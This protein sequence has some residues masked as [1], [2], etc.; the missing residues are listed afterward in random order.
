MAHLNYLYEVFSSVHGVRSRLNIYQQQELNKELLGKYY[1][2]ND[3]PQ[4]CCLELFPLLMDKIGQCYNR[5]I[6]TSRCNLS[7]CD[8]HLGCYPRTPLPLSEGCM[9]RV[10]RGP[11]HLL[12]QA[13]PNGLDHI[14]LK[15]QI[16]THTYRGDF[17]D[18]FI[19]CV[20]G[21]CKYVA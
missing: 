5:F 6:L 10:K 13:N 18:L 14:N 17:S 4:T 19:L 12:S 2:S 9:E 20:S 15:K 7:V 8:G 11:Q 1:W 3:N 16:W 21:L